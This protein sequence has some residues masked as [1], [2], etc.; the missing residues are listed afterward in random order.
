MRASDKTLAFP[1]KFLQAS[2][3]IANTRFQFSLP[4]PK[5]IAVEFLNGFEPF[6]QRFRK[7]Q[8][9]CCAILLCSQV[10]LNVH[11]IFLSQFHRIGR[12]RG[13]LFS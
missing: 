12:E 6:A 4:A 2:L 8:A 11:D 10:K 7:G 5:E 13:R 3:P 1:A 9:N